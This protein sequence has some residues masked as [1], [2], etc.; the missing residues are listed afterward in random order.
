MVRWVR[1]NSEGVPTLGRAEA[2]CAKQVKCPVE[3]TNVE[4]ASYLAG[5]RAPSAWASNL[6]LCFI[7]MRIDWITS[8]SF[9]FQPP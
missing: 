4:N 9:S 2:L 3:E 1:P 8:S 5:L 6:F 7:A